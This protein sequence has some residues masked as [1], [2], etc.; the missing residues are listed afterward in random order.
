LI[1]VYSFPKAVAALERFCNVV[2]LSLK[3]YASYSLLCIT[4]PEGMIAVLG[5]TALKTGSIC[6]FISVIPT[7]KG[8]CTQSEGHT[9]ST[10][11]PVFSLSYLR[12]QRYAE[13]SA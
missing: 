10:I 2:Y 9:D 4:Y 11:S 3:L 8:H 13:V 1:K 5:D 7:K 6:S 12:S